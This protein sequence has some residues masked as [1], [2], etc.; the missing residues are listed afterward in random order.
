MRI[1]YAEAGGIF[2]AKLSERLSFADH[3]AFRKLL[4][5]VAAAAPT[6]CVFDL[7]ELVSIDSAG[8]GMFIIAIEAAK[9]GGWSLSLVGA[10][11]HVKQLLQLSR[12]DRLVTVDVS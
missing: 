7:S 2:E 5:D 9:T 4:D 1:T 3:P 11:G 12:M 10:T 8:L 6:R